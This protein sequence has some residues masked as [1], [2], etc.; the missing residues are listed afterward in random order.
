M[1][2]LEGKTILVVEDEFF[3][4]T[5][6]CRSL[7]AEG[8]QVLGPVGRVDDALG[9]IARSHR[10]D[11]ALVDLNLHGIMAYPVADALTKRS[12]PFLFVT[13]YDCAA[14]PERFKNVPHY[15]KPI[16]LEDARDV[17]FG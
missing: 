7:E 6:L 1:E 15:Q 3:I 9:M 11:G 12:V 8:V 14:I 4:A 16:A 13:G 10:I 2:R 5:D 17:L